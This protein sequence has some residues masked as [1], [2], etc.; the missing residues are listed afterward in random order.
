M[1]ITRNHVEWAVVHRWRELLDD[2]P[3]AEFDVTLQ[4]ALFSSIICWTTQ[5]MRDPQDGPA[6]RVWSDLKRIKFAD[7]VAAIGSKARPALPAAFANL[8]TA[9][10]IIRLRD[11]MAHG[12]ARNVLPINGV[13]NRRGEVQLLGFRFTWSSPEAIFDLDGV[14]M[15]S[16]GIAIADKFCGAFGH[17]QSG[18]AD[19]H[20]VQEARKGVL[21]SNRQ[22]RAS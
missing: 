21:L 22:A 18:S 2:P 17:G 13:P 11:I 6:P 12:D 15:R 16:L 19:G 10:A 5:R 8:N 1:Q 7:T 3:D 14:M 20:F 9:D 4:F